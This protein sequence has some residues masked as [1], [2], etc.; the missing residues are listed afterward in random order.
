MD[1]FDQYGHMSAKLEEQQEMTKVA[2]TL[3][4]QVCYVVF[5]EL[6]SFTYFG[7]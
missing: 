4:T 5:K 6:L 7:I 2:E 1:A 3:A